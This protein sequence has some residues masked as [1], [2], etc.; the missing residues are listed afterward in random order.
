MASYGWGVIYFG[1][2]FVGV[3]IFTNFCF[4]GHNFGS[5]Y[6]TESI[7][8]SKDSDN[9]LVSKTKL[10]PRIGS[11]DWGLGPDKVG[12]KSAKT[13]PLVTSPPENPKPKTK[14]FFQPKDLLNL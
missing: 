6:A 12:Q 11:L 7:K 1:L 4:L 2:A 5:R 3:E 9:S 13:S 10:E 14:T 8:G